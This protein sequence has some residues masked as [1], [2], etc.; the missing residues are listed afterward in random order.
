MT[1]RLRPG[2][3]LFELILAIALSATLLVLI[4]TAINLYL[5]RV[6]TSRQRVEE[7]QLARSILAMIATDLRAAAVYQPQDTSAVA[8]LAANAAAFD[9]DEIDQ[10]SGGAG[11]GGA[12]GGGGG[13]TGGAG[14][15]SG[16][17]T[18]SFGE[19]T[20]GAGGADSTGLGADSST[21]LPL[22]INGTL[23]EL[24]V[25][26]SRLPRV[27]ELLS[28]VATGTA[29]MVQ[30]GPAAGALPRPSDEK[31]VRYF[32]RQGD[33]IDP[34]SAA[35]TALAPEAQL[36]AGGLV[37]QEIDRAV[38]TFA[39]QT[40]NQALLD[41]GQ[42]LVAPEVVQISFR[43]FAGDVAE[44]WNMRERGSLPLAVEV[45]IWL[46]PQTAV[47][48]PEVAESWMSN[49]TATAHQ[50]QQTVY[51]PVTGATSGSAGA[52]SA[53]GSQTGSA[54]ESDQP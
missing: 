16:G 41:S 12:G 44:Y 25:D 39:E 8:Q 22:G 52:A 23:E 50:Y 35:A 15:N 48:A 20:A 33:R 14:G 42:V 54:D 53:T 31:T 34:S 21:E 29:A 32:V 46:T 40:G 26:V 36:R 13:G 51:L 27:D 4:G 11:G 43:Y 18:S 49:P 37:R 2:Y 7:A 19:T 10:P 28:P 45:T 24:I 5:V 1:T 30:S 47:D 9:V 17:E 38:R 6:D 3:T